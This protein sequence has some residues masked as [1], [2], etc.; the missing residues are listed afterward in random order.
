MTARNGIAEAQGT[1]KAIYETQKGRQARG[2]MVFE[3]D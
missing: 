1:M 2:A 3:E